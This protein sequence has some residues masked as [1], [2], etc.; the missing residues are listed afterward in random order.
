MIK[1]KLGLFLEAQLVACFLTRRLNLEWWKKFH[2]LKWGEFKKNEVKPHLKR[3]WC[4]EKLNSQFIWQMEKLLDVYEKPYD[5]KYPV[6]GFDERPCQLIE[7]ILLPQPVE[8]GKEKREDSHY[9]RNG[10]AVVLGAVEP[11]SGKRLHEGYERK[12]K[13][14]GLTWP[15]LNFQHFQSSALIAE[16]ATSVS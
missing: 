12:K 7:D 4:L 9:K 6:V 3:Q 5:P 1:C 15:K 14:A 16:L 11:L 8:P 10:V 2:T 13:Q